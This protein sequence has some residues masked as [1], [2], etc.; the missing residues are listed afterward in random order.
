MIFIGG[1]AHSR[2]MPVPDGERHWKVRDDGGGTSVYTR[3]RF[4]VAG[5]GHRE[6]MVHPVYE[7][8]PLALQEALKDAL[9]ERWLRDGER[10]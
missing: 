5:V 7:G 4:G 9:L 3:Q 10:T 6:L 2:D 1:P 8:A